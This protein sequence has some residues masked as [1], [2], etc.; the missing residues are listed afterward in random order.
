L[1]LTD[2]NFENAW[3]KLQNELDKFSLS[4][5]NLLCLNPLQVSGVKRPSSGGTALAVF[6]V[7]C[8]QL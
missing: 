4:Q 3:F 8:V 2:F 1:V 5:T 7:S 6:G